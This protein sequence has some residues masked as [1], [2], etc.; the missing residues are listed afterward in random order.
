MKRKNKGM[1]SP[2]GRLSVLVT[3]IGL[4]VILPAGRS[5]AGVGEGTLPV[6]TPSPFFLLRIRNNRVT[7]RVREVDRLEV[8]R[9]VTELAGLEF[10]IYQKPSGKISV[11]FQALPL[12]DCL[13]KLLPDY[14][15]VYRPD[16]SGRVVL[17]EVSVFK[18]RSPSPGVIYSHL[19]TLP[20]GIRPGEAGLIDVPEMERLGPQTFAVDGEGNIYLAD[21]VNRRLQVFSPEGKLKTI[22]KDV[23]RVSGLAVS[24]GGDVFALDE[25]R[26]L[27]R[28]YNPEGKL[29]GEV[30]VPAGLMAEKE[31]I[32]FQAGEVWLRSRDGE[33]WAVARLDKGRMISSPEKRPAGKGLRSRDGKLISVVKKSPREAEIAIRDRGGKLSRKIAL[34][35]ANL[36]SVNLLGEDPDGHLLLQV[37]QF[38]PDRP[39]INLEVFKI[40][41]S[42]KTLARSGKIRNNYMN[43]TARLLRLNSRG[44]IYQM[45]PGPKG[46]EL[47]HWRWKELK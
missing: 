34:P 46:V 18:T 28:Y 3:A 1:F 33:E 27:L 19:K 14:G 10:K 20:Y 44:D 6:P 15:F 45:L 42:G 35:I 32:R 30:K 40:D 17:R 39:G 8:A 38:H 29:R 2:A 31:T 11:D 7:L 16:S 23:G 13:K 5:A 26:N 36:A 24:E 9:R 37:E 41:L 43:W 12:E 25:E 21:T 4:L 22:I 47:N